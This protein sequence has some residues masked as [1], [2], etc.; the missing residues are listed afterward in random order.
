M[1]GEGNAA[2]SR[3]VLPQLLLVEDDLDLSQLLREYLSETYVVTSRATGEAGLDA[4]L[5]H[6]FDVLVLDRRLPGMD[7]VSVVTAVRRAGIRTP[8][9]ILT[10]MGSIDD[11]VSG[12]DSGANDYL[13][14][15][16]DFEELGARL[17]ALL[18]GFRE[19]LPNLRVGEW[20]YSPETGVLYGIAGER[21]TL[22]DAENT[23]LRT[24]SEAPDRVFTRQALLEAAFSAEDSP[25]TIDTYVH[26]LREKLGWDAVETVRGR[27][28]R[29]G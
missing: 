20:H 9:L 13:V 7:G 14:K 19:S 21:V 23:L 2:P 4:A 29:I 10:A 28:Y 12:L 18:R 15:P 8:V 6:R 3:R 25:G 22:T 11:R 26:Y 5:R 24:L 16:F 17:R 1:D 27:G